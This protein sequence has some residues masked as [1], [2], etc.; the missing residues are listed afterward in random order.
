MNVNAKRYLLKQFLKWGRG[1]KENGG[2]GEFKYEIF[3]TL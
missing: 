3:D 2:E 1:I